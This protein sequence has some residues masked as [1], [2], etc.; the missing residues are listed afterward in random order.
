[1]ECNHIDHVDL[2]LEQ[3]LPDSSLFAYPQYGRKLLIRC[4]LQDMTN[5]V[6]STPAHMEKSQ[7]RVLRNHFFISNIRI[8]GINH[9]FLLHLSLN[10]TI[11]L[12]FLCEFIFLLI[13]FH[14]PLCNVRQAYKGSSIKVAPSHVISQR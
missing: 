14:I 6:L 8:I 11:C 9:L 10:F 12:I 5:T 1:M 7:S 4:M 3:S 13:I 2:E